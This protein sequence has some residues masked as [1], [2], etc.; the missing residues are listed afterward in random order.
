MANPNFAN[1]QAVNQPDNVLTQLLQ[2][3]MRN[4]QALPNDMNNLDY[5]M[6]Q[7]Q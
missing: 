2:A 6:M 3:M 5:S 4:Q 1:P 7:Q